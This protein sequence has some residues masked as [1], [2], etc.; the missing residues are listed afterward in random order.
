MQ[1]ATLLISSGAPTCQLQIKN[2]REVVS[3]SSSSDGQSSDYVRHICYLATKTGKL[4]QYELEVTEAELRIISSSKQKVKSTLQTRSL[5]VKEIPKQPR[6]AN[7]SDEDTAEDSPMSL[8]NTQ[9]NTDKQAK[10]QGFWYPIKLVLPQN[11]SRT[12]FTETRRSR[13]QLIAAIHATQGF[14][15]A[16]EQYTIEETIGEGSCNPVWKGFHKITGTRVAIKS[17]DTCKYQRLSTENQV[18]EGRAMYMCQSSTQVINFIEEFTINGETYIVTKLARGGDLL[19][20]LTALGVDRLPEDRAKMIVRQIAQ[21]LSEIHQNGVVHRDLKHLNIFL[22]DQSEAPKIKIGDFGLACKLGQDECIKKMAGT[23][24][25]MAP[26]VVKDEPSD[27]KSD[28]WSLGVIL[29][30]LIGSGVP[31]SGRDR[32]TTAHNIINQELSFDRSVWQTVSKE[33]KDLLRKML[34]KDQ[35]ER[36]SINEVVKH[37]WFAN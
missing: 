5:H 36:I 3:T 23:I 4:C 11:K 21:G 10:K 12:V 14:S 32:D 24:G 9:A 15:N 6:E 7:S 28:I 25:F 2:F 31:F 29:Y 17:M 22:S 34:I 19:S 30:A 20:Y 37:A 1:S 26:E 16:L 13:K 35:D 27:F 8:P 18:S 33:C